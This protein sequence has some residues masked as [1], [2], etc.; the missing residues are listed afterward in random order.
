[1]QAG[2][3][4]PH[5]TSGKVKPM[6]VVGLIRH[7]EVVRGMPTGWLSAADIQVW[8][9]E[10]D[11]AAVI[12]KPVSLG[13]AVWERWMSSDVKRAR[14]TAQAIGPGPWEELPELRE[15]QI[16]VLRTGTLR[17]PFPVWRWIFRWMWMTS[18]RSQKAIKEELLRNVTYVAKEILAPDRR[19]TLVVSHAGVM[20]FL[21]RELLK[22]G[23][24][25]PRFKVAEHGRLYLFE[26]D[27][28]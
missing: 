5:A 13:E 21:H 9:T 23:F 11:T 12:Q 25:G 8:Q 19:N 28:E 24:A 2:A 3:C 17:L 14:E 15:P 6:K 4:H 18:H 27:G 10:Y 22:Q 26:R 16:S 20:M 1:L 7:F